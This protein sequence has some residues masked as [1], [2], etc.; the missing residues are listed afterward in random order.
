MRNWKK[1]VDNFTEPLRY[2]GIQQIINIVL[3]YF[4]CFHPCT[5]HCW[6]AAMLDL[7]FCTSMYEGHL[8]YLCFHLGD[9]ICFTNHYRKDD[10]KVCWKMWNPCDTK[11]AVIIPTLWPPGGNF[12]G[13][14]LDTVL[15]DWHLFGRWLAVIQLQFT[16]RPLL[17]ACKHTFN[18]CDFSFHHLW[19]CSSIHVLLCPAKHFECA[20]KRSN[21]TNRQDLESSSG[22]GNLIFLIPFSST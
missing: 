17:T 13:L 5:L 16:K 21:G 11:V 6:L 19:R 14:I 7:L 15:L 8:L 1:I 3:I 20:K 18:F 9:L 10:R 2:W 4:V 22:F 12:P